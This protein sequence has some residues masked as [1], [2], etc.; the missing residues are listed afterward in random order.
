MEPLSP[1]APKP[2]YFDAALQAWVLSSY[3]EVRAALAEPALE[4]PRGSGESA[5]TRTSVLE[6]LPAS[7]AAEWAQAAEE[8][9][10]KLFQ[11]LPR[12]RPIDLVSDVAHPWSR[13]LAILLTRDGP[14][15]RRR[16]LRLVSGRQCRSSRPGPLGWFRNAEFEFFFR[17]RP[18]DKSAFIG[19]SETL[20]G[21]LANAWV[22]LLRVPAELARLRAQPELAPTAIEELLRYAGLVH[23]LVRQASADVDLG[24][25]RIRA[26]DR[27]I[28]KLQSANRDPRQFPCPDRLDV[29][30]SQSAHL[31]LGHGR[32]YCAGALL[33]GVAALAITRRFA[34][35]FSNAHINGD[36]RW[37]WGT[38]L[39][40][41]SNALIA[42]AR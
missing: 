23:T 11:A 20:P 38:A 1:P 29:T 2:A 15:Y 6:A 3:A 41:P 37:C 26:G 42:S 35:H 9:G 10:A 33:L 39:V 7:H 16:L 5:H 36:I 40:S 22:A 8:T 13:E 27:A 17:K 21:F 14:Q 18:G 24:G 25:I 28:L 31:A 32:H 34:G 12:N 19:I 4:Q 30:R